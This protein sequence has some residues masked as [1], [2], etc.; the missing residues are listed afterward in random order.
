MA[1]LATLAEILPGPGDWTEADY[2]LVSERG[3][4]VELSDGDIEV[5]P[6]PTENHQLLSARVYLGLHTFVSV[7]H[8]GK[9]RYAPLPVRL[10][11]GKIREPDVMYMS[12]DHLD[13]I[14][15]YW[16]VPDLVV[17]IVSE[18]GHLH[19]KRIKR[20]EYAAAGIPEYWIV[21]AEAK[22]VELLELDAERASYTGTLLPADATL[23]SRVLPGFTLSL[24]E[25]FAPED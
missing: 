2:Q 15:R 8:L 13:R 4:L 16:G 20:A 12:N 17:E 19:D 6:V 25:L 5:L 9:V 3:R 23:V 7:N 11:E 22:T 14:G 21:D 18:G 1:S 24:A 10:W